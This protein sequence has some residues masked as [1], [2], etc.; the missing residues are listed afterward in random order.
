MGRLPGRGP[1]PW[2]PCVGGPGRERPRVAC[3]GKTLLIGGDRVGVELFKRMKQLGRRDVD[4][5][6]E[7]TL[8]SR[9][10]NRRGQVAC[11]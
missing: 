7:H 9:F 3:W 1:A 2:L 4:L 10:R 5:E 8:A 6:L 11:G